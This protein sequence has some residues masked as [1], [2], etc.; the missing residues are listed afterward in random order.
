[1]WKEKYKLN[2]KRRR[3]GKIRE[4]MKSWVSER[5]TLNWN[6]IQAVTKQYRVKKVKLI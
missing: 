1:M 2:K 5:E 4:G 3:N 6:K